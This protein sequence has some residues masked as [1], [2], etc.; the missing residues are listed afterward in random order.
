MQ[1]FMCRFSAPSPRKFQLTQHYIS[2]STCCLTLIDPL[3]QLVSHG[4]TDGVE[5][6]THC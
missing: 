1:N 3:P 2:S 4:A 5:R 6:F